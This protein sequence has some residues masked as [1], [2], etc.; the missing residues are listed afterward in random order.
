MGFVRS[1]AIDRRP[2]INL[3]CISIC[4]PNAN[5]GKLRRAMLTFFCT[6]CGTCLEIDPAHAG[7]LAR[8]GQC[9]N[10]VRTPALA[11]DEV[12]FARVAAIGYVVPAPLSYVPAWPERHA[13]AVMLD[14]MAER[15]LHV[16][17]PDEAD[18]P[19]SMINCRYCGSTIAPFIRKCRCRNWGAR[20]HCRGC[21]CSQLAARS[22]YSTTS[23]S[24]S[25]RD[26][27]LE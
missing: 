17:A 2:V 20:W 9:S 4:G 21:L 27:S 23:A 5:D 18:D 10:H 6:R 8:C 16:E 3:R 14:E 24:A 1:V 22:L 26:V 15:L 12:P 11:A 7:E 19:D 25:S 13:H